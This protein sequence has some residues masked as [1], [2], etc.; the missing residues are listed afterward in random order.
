[1]NTFIWQSNWNIVKKLNRL[2]PVPASVYLSRWE[3]SSVWLKMKRSQQTWCYCRQIV[4]MA[5]V[6]LPQPVLT[7][8]PISRSDNNM[9]GAFKQTWRCLNLFSFVTVRVFCCCKHADMN[10][11]LNN[12]VRKMWDQFYKSSVWSESLQ[13]V[14]ARTSDGVNIQEGKLMIL[15][16]V[17]NH[18]ANGLHIKALWMESSSLSLIY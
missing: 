1:M 2:Y 7:E 10:A 16:I 4:Q 14:I 12:L 6:T 17:K 11:W 3:T 5:P 13:W 18:K 15:L 9:S 8:R